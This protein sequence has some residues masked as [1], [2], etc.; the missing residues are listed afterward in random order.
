M[1][2]KVDLAAGIERTLPTL[3]LEITEVKSDYSGPQWTFLESGS[4]VLT[5]LGVRIFGVASRVAV[6]SLENRIGN[7]SITASVAGTTLYFENS[8]FAGTLNLVART[9]GPNSTFIFHL[10]GSG[11][12]NFPRS[13]PLLGTVRYCG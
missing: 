5:R 3:G 4:E 8:T 9:Q 2:L 13:S 7:V 12:T 10:V 11:V 1:S 6:T